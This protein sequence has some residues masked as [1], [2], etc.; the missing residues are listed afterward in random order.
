MF[1]AHGSSSWPVLVLRLPVADREPMANYI[2]L[3][4]VTGSWRPAASRD[5]LNCITPE[6]V[7]TFVR[8]Q[9]LRTAISRRVYLYGYGRLGKD[10]KVHRQGTTE[11]NAGRLFLKV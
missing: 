7:V 2:M 8:F 5:A 11:G 4:L 10:V 1:A 6:S 9:A 3:D